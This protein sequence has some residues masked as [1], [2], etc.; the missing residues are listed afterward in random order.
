MRCLLISASPSCGLVHRPSPPLSFPLTLHIPLPAH[1]AQGGSHYAIR[2]YFGVH[3]P[4]FKLYFGSFLTIIVADPEVARA[5]LYRY[6]NHAEFI[7][8]NLR[9]VKGVHREME[10]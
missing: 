4:I 7:A 9:L 5:V 3:G 1:R 6:T 8:S 10:R 2:E